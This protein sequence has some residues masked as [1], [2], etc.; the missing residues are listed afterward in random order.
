MDSRPFRATL[1]AL[2][3]AAAA[4]KTQAQKLV[5]R[6]HE[7]GDVFERLY[8]EYAPADGA[9]PA[10]ADAGLVGRVI[11]EMDRTYFEQH[12]LAIGRGERPFAL[13]GKLEA[14]MKEPAHTRACRKA[15]D[16]QLEIGALE[17]EVGSAR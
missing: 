3:L 15:A 6:R 5:D 12:C 10:A 16:L 7:L 11:G 13:T 14:F 2:A 17:R 1:A 9:A 8:A 4:C